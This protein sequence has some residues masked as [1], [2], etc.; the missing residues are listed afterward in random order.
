MEIGLW[1]LGG[2]EHMETDQLDKL[3][4]CSNGSKNTETDCSES[5]KITPRPTKN[6]KDYTSDVKSEQARFSA[7]CSGNE[8]RDIRIFY[9]LFLFI[10]ARSHL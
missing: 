7:P 3:F 5:N 10:Y 6:L 2:G 8:N 9:L 1:L 4:G